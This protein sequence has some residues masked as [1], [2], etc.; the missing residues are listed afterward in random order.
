[1]GAK[2]PSGPHRAPP[3]A[4]FVQPAEVA[5]RGRGSKASPSQQ[6]NATGTQRSNSDALLRVLS[7][8]SQPD[9]TAINLR[10]QVHA[11]LRC[12]SNRCGQWTR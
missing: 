11:Q 1:M 5:R 12:A 4:N 10:S 6:P 7:Q 3:H 8:R 9:L 2:Q